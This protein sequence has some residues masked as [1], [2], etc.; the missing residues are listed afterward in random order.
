MPSAYLLSRSARCYECDRKLEKGE[1]AKLIHDSEERELFCAKCAHLDSLELLAKGD[2]KLTRL[3][4]KYSKTKYSLLKWSELWKTYERQGL[5][6]EPEAIA[7][8][9]RELT[10]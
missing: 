10:S 6:L 7:K 5:L 2:A 4:S 9:K 8:A 3:A 1:I